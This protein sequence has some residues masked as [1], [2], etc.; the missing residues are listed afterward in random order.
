MPHKAA[1]LMST[2]AVT[3]DPT[4]IVERRDGIFA[5]TDIRS[6]VEALGFGNRA[7]IA[8]AATAAD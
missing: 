3:S 8:G 7:D 2:N 1:L 5:A 4:N 6:L